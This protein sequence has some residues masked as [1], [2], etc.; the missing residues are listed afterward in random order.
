LWSIGDQF[1]D[2]S[3]GNGLGGEASAQGFGDPLGALGHLFPRVLVD[4]ASGV[5]ELV[6]ALR[7]AGPLGRGAVALAAGDLDDDTGIVEQEVDAGERA[8][9]STMDHLGSRPRQPRT[10]Y[11]LEKAALEH[12]VS[13]GVD[14]EVVK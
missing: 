10:A 6:A 14:E 12:R 7:V 1:G 5:L 11:E 9:T 4:S 2:S 13:S 3:E 8:A